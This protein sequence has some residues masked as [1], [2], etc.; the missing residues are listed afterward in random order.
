MVTLQILLLSSNP[1]VIFNLLQLVQQGWT[2]SWFVLYPQG[3]SEAKFAVV[4]AATIVFY[5]A[6]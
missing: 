2:Q 4:V 1:T 3:R 5:G 6:S